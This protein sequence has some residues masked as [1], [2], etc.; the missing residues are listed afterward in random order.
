MISV[1]ICVL[2]VLSFSYESS[3]YCAAAEPVCEANGDGADGGACAVTSNTNDEAAAAAAAVVVATS[4]ED[5]LDEA[6]NR[7]IPKGANSQGKPKEVK[8][9]V[10]EDRHEMCRGNAQNGECDR[11]PGWMIVNCPRSCNKCHLLDPKVRCSRNHLNIS[12]DPIYPPNAINE[13][14]SSIKSKFSSRYTINVLSESPWVVTFDDFLTDR[15]V[16]AL[17]KT[18]EGTWERSTDTGQVNEYGET[19]RVLSTGRTSSNAWCRSRCES[20]PDVKSVMAKIEE[21]TGIPREN[22]ES[23]QILRYEPSQYYNTHHDMAP[24]QNN[25]ACGPR[26][27]TFFLYLSDV[28]EG[29]E[30]AFPML[31][32]NVKPKRGRALLWP[33]VKNE[34]TTGIVTV[35]CTS[36]YLLYHV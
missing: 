10:C 1:F 31:N 24:H 19:G 23:F 16:K 7:K 4:H 27:L 6:G 21:V 22:S 29:G 9:G 20:H 14:F 33:S 8:L 3:L 30:T 36:A 25:L 12:T 17:I 28:D 15:E 35:S 11:N 18:V 34:D 32:I 26:I 5:D 2:V 13:M